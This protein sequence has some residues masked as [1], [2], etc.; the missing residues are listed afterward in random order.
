MLSAN[1][2][3]SELPARSEAAP[4]PLRCGPLPREPLAQ[5]PRQRRTASAAA[6]AAADLFSIRQTE[7]CVGAAGLPLR[8]TLF[9]NNQ[10]PMNRSH[11]PAV[12]VNRLL[13]F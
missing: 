1:A 3:A 6:P 8:L 4:C 7:G 11:D 5:R 2:A 9:C 12:L 10:V 13:H